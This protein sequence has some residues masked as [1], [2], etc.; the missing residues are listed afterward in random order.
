[1]ATDQ[2]LVGSVDLSLLKDAVIENRNGKNFVVIP[3]EDN[4]ALFL[5]SK[6][7]GEHVYMDIEVRP[8]PNNQYGNSH[9]VKLN[10]SRKKREA[11]GIAKED[12]KSIAPI[13][14]N[15]KA[16]GTGKAQDAPEDLPA[17][18]DTWK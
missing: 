10:V 4:P 17:D 11:L 7:K 3:I 8:S 15:L 13:I 1:M 5:G 6:E 9:F 12:L 18:D 14:G 2:N 16:Y